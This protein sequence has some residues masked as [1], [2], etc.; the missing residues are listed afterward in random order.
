MIGSRVEVR[1]Q[2][3]TRDMFLLIRVLVGSIE[4]IEQCNWQVWKL[5]ELLLLVMM[6]FD[7]RHRPSSS[8][9]S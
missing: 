1:E 3:K 6:L 7:L 8:K 4:Q 9:R 5:P 2:L